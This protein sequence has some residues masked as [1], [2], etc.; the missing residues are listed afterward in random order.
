MVGIVLCREDKNGKLERWG[1]II[2]RQ[3]KTHQ[4]DKGTGFASWRKRRNARIKVPR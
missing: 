2:G 1:I 3:R 4:Q